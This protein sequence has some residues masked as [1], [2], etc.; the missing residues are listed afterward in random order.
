MLTFVLWEVGQVH[1]FEN[2]LRSKLLFLSISHV[3]RCVLKG[4][5]ILG[6]GYD[7][8]VV[9]LPYLLRLLLAVL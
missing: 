4:F 1:H 6:V 7:F 3:K 8:V 9:A 5:S 2:H